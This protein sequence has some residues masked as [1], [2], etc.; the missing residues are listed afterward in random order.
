MQ[1]HFIINVALDGQHL[2]ATAAHSAVDHDKAETLFQL[3][4]VKFPSSQG[5]SITL[6]EWTGQGRMIKEVR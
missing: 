4:L 3:F 1:S 6:T 2:F 5:Y